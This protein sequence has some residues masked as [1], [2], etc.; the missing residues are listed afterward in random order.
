MC[1][2]AFHTPWLPSI[3][4]EAPD[5]RKLHQLQEFMSETQIVKSKCTM[6]DI[7]SKSVKFGLLLKP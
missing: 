5:Y 1:Q 7:G 2:V 3:Y 4:L 6:A